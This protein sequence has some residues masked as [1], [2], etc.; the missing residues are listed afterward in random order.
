MGGASE[1]IFDDAARKPGNPSWVEGVWEGTVK[2]NGR[3]PTSAS[4]EVVDSALQ[5]RS[6]NKS[7][8]YG[9]QQKYNYQA[10]LKTFDRVIH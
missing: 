4:S 5:L 10:K 9:L 8:G 3:K 7:C 6:F 1:R 2:N